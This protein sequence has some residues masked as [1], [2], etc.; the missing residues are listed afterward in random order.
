MHA[1]SH[2]LKEERTYRVVLKICSTPSTL[3]RS[4]PKFKT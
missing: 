2:K 3:K 1:I 4:K